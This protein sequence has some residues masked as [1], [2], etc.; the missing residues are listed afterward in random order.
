MRPSV[1]AA[2]EDRYYVRAHLYSELNMVSARTKP[3]LFLIESLTLDD[4]KAERQEGDIIS[5]MLHLAGKTGTQYY[6]IRTVRELEEMIDLFDDSEY[7]YLHISCHANRSGMATTFDEVPYPV[8]GEMLRPCLSKRRVFVSACQ[9]ASEGLAKELL[10]NSG[11][12]SLIGPKQSIDFDNAAAFWVSF[13]HLMFKADELKMTRENLQRRITE[14]SALYD[15]P[16]NYFTASRQCKQGF[17]R[18]RNLTRTKNT[19]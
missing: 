5:R 4:E 8:L 19:G 3:E 11:C 1:L 15:E 6:Y 12:N 18:V 2:H 16:I 13:Y 9:M 7:R 17:K 10:P 14:L